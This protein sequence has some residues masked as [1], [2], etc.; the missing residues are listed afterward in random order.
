MGIGMMIGSKKR[1]GNIVLMKNFISHFAIFMVALSYLILTALIGYSLKQSCNIKEVTTTAEI[2]EILEADFTQTRNTRITNAVV[3]CQYSY[4]GKEYKKET[5]ID[6][7]CKKGDII[8]I[9]VDAD[10]PDVII[11][12]T[13]QEKKVCFMTLIITAVI[14]SALVIAL[15]IPRRK[16]RKQKNP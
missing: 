5:S 14:M 11:N 7:G 13:N 10:N 12:F 15:T 16:I 2:I 6:G 1:G 3:L 9:V 4:E 8:D